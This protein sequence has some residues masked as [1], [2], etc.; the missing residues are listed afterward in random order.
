M[1]TKIPN[2]TDK[3]RYPN[4]Y[5]PSEKTDITQTFE[6]ARAKIKAEEDKV[7]GKPG[8]LFPVAKKA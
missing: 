5:T 3:F 6:I 8:V 1:A 7:R 2:F 4:G